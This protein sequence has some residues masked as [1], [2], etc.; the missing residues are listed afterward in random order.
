M[1][2]GCGRSVEHVRFG[3][4]ASLHPA[5]L[6]CVGPHQPPRGPHSI[7]TGLKAGETMY[8]TGVLPKIVQNAK[9]LFSNTLQFVKLQLITQRT[10]KNTLKIEYELPTKHS[11]N[12]CATLLLRPSR[13]ARAER[14]S[15]DG[16]QEGRHFAPPSR[17]Q[18]Q[19]TSS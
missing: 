4:W 14:P 5:T 17:A 12:R 9:Y 6:G 15:G 16:G 19:N 13:W 1:E 8:Q 18:K 10:A 7:W 11:K 3:R 2:G